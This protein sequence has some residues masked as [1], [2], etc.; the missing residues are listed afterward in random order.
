LDSAEFSSAHDITLGEG[1]SYR[2]IEDIL[3]IEPEIAASLIRDHQQ[4]K[5]RPPPLGHIGQW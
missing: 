4:F 1:L 3:R 5:H 2:L